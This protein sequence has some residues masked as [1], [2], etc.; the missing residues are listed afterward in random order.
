[1]ASKKV[2]L[3]IMDGWGL[4]QVYDSDAIRHGQL[5]NVSLLHEILATV[6]L[7]I[8]I[9]NLSGGGAFVYWS[10]KS[11]HTNVVKAG[12]EPAHIQRQPPPEILDRFG[13][14]A[15][16]EP[17]TIALRVA[18]PFDRDRAGRGPRQRHFS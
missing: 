8:Q 2:I 11:P 10:K 3:V 1:M 13:R 9:R 7:P 6:Q 14:L 12:V 15:P 5:K 18:G 16:G 17:R 4:G